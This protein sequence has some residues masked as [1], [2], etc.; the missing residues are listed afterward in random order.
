MS[1]VYHQK[2]TEL[3]E[4]L[5]V[6]KLGKCKLNRTKYLD[7]K[8]LQIVKGQQRQKIVNVIGIWKYNRIP[9]L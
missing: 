4:K 5:F 2:K 7:T 1:A 3:N 9:K 8:T 6:I